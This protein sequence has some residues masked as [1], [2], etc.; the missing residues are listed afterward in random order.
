MSIPSKG[1][2]TIATGETDCHELYNSKGIRIAICDSEEDAKFLLTALGNA[3]PDPY[4]GPPNMTD[5]EIW[6]DELIEILDEG[7]INENVENND[8]TPSQMRDAKKKLRSALIWF[9]QTHL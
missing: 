5:C 7:F 4:Q 2:F 9:Y 1:P 6:S 8:A 3:I